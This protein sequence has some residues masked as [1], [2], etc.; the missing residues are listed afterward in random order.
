[1][2]HRAAAVGAHRVAGVDHQ[3]HHRRLQLAAVGAH[4]RQVAAVVGVQLDVLAQQAAQQHLELA[5]QLAE[6]ED[7]ALHGLLAREGQQLADQVG[8]ARR[9]SRG[10]RSGP[11]RTD[12]PRGGAGSS[13]S[14]CMAMAVS[15][16]LK[17]WATPP[18]SWPMA[19]ILRW[20]SCSSICFCSVTSWTIDQGP[21]A[22]ARPG[23]DGRPD[24]SRPPGS[25]S[26]GPARPA[27]CWARTSSRLAAS[28]TVR[29]ARARP[30]RRPMAFRAALE[31]ADHAGERVLADD[32]GDAEGRRPRQADPG[33]D[34]P[35][36]WAPA[37]RL[38]AGPGTAARRPWRSWPAAH[39]PG[40]M[41]RPSLRRG[42]GLR[43]GT[44]STRSAVCGRVPRLPARR[45][46]RATIAPSSRGEA[47]RLVQ[48]VQQ[49]GRR[50]RGFARTQ[51]H[52]RILTEHLSHRREE[53]APAVPSCSPC[54]RR[55]PQALTPAGQSRRE[56]GRRLGRGAFVGVAVDAVV[57]ARAWP[58]R[59]SRRS[60]AAARASRR[61]SSARF[62]EIRITA[63]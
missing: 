8:G 44:G 28:M 52:R 12:R 11:R 40:R 29:Q 35:W 43:P 45:R 61:A 19:C 24:R 39:P 5:D 48:G 33:L 17:S 57:G 4:Q 1:M 36:P 10:S 56:H 31:A 51:N 20:A 62:G 34:R 63:S 49:V 50:E 23:A 37:A 41:P 6:V 27:A 18:A 30:A 38:P 46:W 42:R 14:S 53:G 59:G 21:A 7:L 15:R 3:V 60:A 26:N 13:S 47:R 25:T 16:L 9:R 55:K 22:G 32:Q 2:L 54:G 58:R